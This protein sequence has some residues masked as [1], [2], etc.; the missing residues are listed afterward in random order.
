MYDCSRNGIHA[1]EAG[2]NRD[3]SLIG[4]RVMRTSLFRLPSSIFHQY[5]FPQHEQWNGSNLLKSRVGMSRDLFL[6]FLS[7]RST[8]AGFANGKILNTVL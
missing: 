7:C 2:R 6:V 5:I 4:H 3:D 1:W 8:D